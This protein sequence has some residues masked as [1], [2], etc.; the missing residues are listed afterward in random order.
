V[1]EYYLPDLVRTGARVLLVA[2][3]ADTARLLDLVAAGVTGIVDTSEPPRAV[4]DGILELA[5]GGAALPGRVTAAIAAD[6]RR[7]RRTRQEGQ[8]RSDLT[9]REAEILGAMSDGLSTKA[10]AHHLGIA[11]KTVENHKTRVFDKLG[12]RT[13]AEAVMVALGSPRAAR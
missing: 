12:V 5:G 13:T 11:V 4:V 1:I 9:A 8:A 7:T 3:P 6:W 2:D 10:I